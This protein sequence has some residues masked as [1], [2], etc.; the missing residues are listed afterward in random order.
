M[1]AIC[2]NN[3]FPHSIVNCAVSLVMGS[4]GM[5]SKILFYVGLLVTVAAVCYVFY[6]N[7]ETVTVK[8]GKETTWNAPIAMVLVVTFFL[9]VSLSGAFSILGAAR[10]RY[11]NWR[12]NR[13]YKLW[14]SHQTLILSAR[15]QIAI[16]NFK[17]ANSLLRRV[18]E[19][20]PD[21]IVARFM[22][23]KA[24][25]RAG[26]LKE[27]VRVLDQA[28]LSQKSNV[29]LLA[30]A[31][32]INMKLQNFTAAYD[33]LTILLDIQPDTPL[34]LKRLVECADKLGRFEKA[35]DFQQT[36]MR[37]APPSEQLAAQRELARLELLNVKAKAGGDKLA[38]R[39]GIEEILR[40]HKD[41]PDALSELADL[42]RE[43]GNPESATKLLLKAFKQ[44]DDTRA[45]ETVTEMWLG[46]ENPE[47]AISAIKA[48]AESTSGKLFFINLLIHLESIDEAQAEFD[49]LNAGSF[50]S[51]QEKDRLALVKAKLMK[52]RGAAADAAAELT[53]ALEPKV[54]LPG[55]S[56]FN[57]YLT[58]KGPGWSA[59]GSEL[60]ASPAP[61]IF[62]GSGG[63]DV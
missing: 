36:V 34:V 27:A 16:N 25:M 20:D 53:A 33:N 29:E 18:L 10:E 56:F 42:E 12:E 15:E 17:T 8:F 14:Q 5:S 63:L 4:K 54:S 37:L 38:L 3:R 40:R 28:R 24:A 43:S 59:A 26:D 22:V 52:R 21:N 23:A 9:G 62:H 60:E 50:S 2:I 11:V 39:A 46:M 47:K 19:Q 32:E 57:R 30:L 51:A 48:A 55:D 61:Q 35:V 31:S 13:K 41:Y 45:L 6:H 58:A 44:S 1:V 7:P 49:K